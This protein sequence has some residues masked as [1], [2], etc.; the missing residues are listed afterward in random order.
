VA[1]A[2]RIADIGGFVIASV[3]TAAALG[4][5]VWVWGFALR[6]LFELADAM[7]GFSSGNRSAR[8]AELGPRETREM[9][10]RFNEMA[11]ALQR[12]RENQL[13][14]LSSVAHDLRNPLS[15]LRMSAAL[16]SC[17]SVELSPEQVRRT[18]A[19]VGRQVDSLERMVGDLLDATRIEAGKLELRIED[20]DARALARDVV[21]IYWESDKRPIELA[22]AEEP[23][24]ICC[25]ATR[26]GQ[27]LHNLVSNAIKYS[28][29]GSPIQ[30]SVRRD[31]REVVFAVRDRGIGIRPEE[32]GRIFEPFRRSGEA[33]HVAGGVGLGLSVARRIVQAHSGR[34]DVQSTPGQGSIFRVHIPLAS[35]AHAQ[36]AAG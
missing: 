10:R 21:E 8:A 28:G 2:D 19:L 15:A 9:A 30:M 18:L 33:R 36:R 3:L 26:I 20:H 34:I 25:D 29:E 27:V 13:T 22:V 6:P 12:E 16:A 5:L 1:S 24:P 32:L 4:L 23:L 35:P 14:F 11:S 7:E 17:E 31:G